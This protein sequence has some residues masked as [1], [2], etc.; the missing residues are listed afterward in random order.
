MKKSIEL[1][2]ELLS[3]LGNYE[4]TNIFEENQNHEYEGVLFN[5][6]DNSYR[7]RLAKLTPKKKGYFVVFWEKDTS[8]QNQAYRYSESPDKI[9]V[10]VIDNQLKGQFIFPKSILMKQKVLSSD[11]SKGKM[12]I[13][14][15]PSWEKDL[16]N[17]AKK[18]QKWQTDFFID[19]SEN[20]DMKKLENVCIHF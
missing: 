20:I 17:Y 5:I 12:A 1:T 19:L 15:Y 7:S 6:V 4:I 8:N 3:Y 10:S 14:V 11:D 18:T 2:K 16:N 13:R 9:I